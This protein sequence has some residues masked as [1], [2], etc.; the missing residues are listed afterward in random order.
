MCRDGH[1]IDREAAPRGGHTGADARIESL[2]SSPNVTV[3]CGPPWARPGACCIDTAPAPPTPPR[4]RNAL[5]G[6]VPGRG[7]V[8]RPVWG[9]TLPWGAVHPPALQSHPAAVRAC[10]RMGSRSDALASAASSRTAAS[11]NR[12]PDSSGDASARSTSVA[13]VLADGC[14]MRPSS[15]S[16]R[17]PRHRRATDVAVVAARLAHARQPLE[18]LELL[19]Q[20]ALVVNLWVLGVEPHLDVHP[21]QPRRHRGAPVRRPNHAPA[22]HLRAVRQVLQR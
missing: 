14:R 5:R 1:P 19:D 13:S 9:T 15:P 18:L 21:D 3:L 6:A 11:S 2:R 16:A 7:G 20:P 8:P 17:S 4:S 10:G 12:S 22:A